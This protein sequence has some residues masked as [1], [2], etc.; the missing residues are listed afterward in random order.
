MVNNKRNRVGYGTVGQRAFQAA[1][2]LVGYAGN[3]LRSRSAPAAKR[4]SGG[5]KKGRQTVQMSNNPTS[6]T[7]TATKGK[8]AIRDKIVTF[9]D[10]KKEVYRI[11]KKNAEVLQSAKLY[12][13]IPSQLSTAVNQA[14][15]IDVQICNYS[16]FDGVLANLPQTDSG[17]ISG[18]IDVAYF[19]SYSP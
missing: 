4:R 18:T 17:M 12:E 14:N 9:S 13:C 2:A 8:G 3:Q 1:S 5:P 6:K 11:K 15:Y 10:L 7:T 16:N 19:S